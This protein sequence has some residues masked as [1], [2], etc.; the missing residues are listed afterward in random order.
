MQERKSSY[1]QDKDGWNHPQTVILLIQLKSNKNF[2]N[3]KKM[4]LKRNHAL[5][6]LQ[7]T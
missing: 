5:Y 3:Y 7:G 1:F 6:L 4:S 2:W